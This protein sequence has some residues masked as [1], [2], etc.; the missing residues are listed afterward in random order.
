MGSE[1]SSKWSQWGRKIVGAR[2]KEKMVAGAWGV[3]NRH[4]EKLYLASRAGA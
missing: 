1:N 3:R 2:G 4:G